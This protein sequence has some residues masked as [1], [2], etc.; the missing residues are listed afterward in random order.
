MPLK[1]YQAHAPLHIFGEDFR[2]R[3]EG[4]VDFHQRITP[5]RMQRTETITVQYHQP[6]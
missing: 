4:D 1:T 6:F 2:E 3:D 5:K